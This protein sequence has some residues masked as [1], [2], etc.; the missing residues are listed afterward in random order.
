MA[1]VFRK[2]IVRHYG[3]DGKRCLTT[4]PGAARKV[5][6]SRKWYG[7]VGRQQVPLCSDKTRSQQMLN[8][9]LTDVAMRQHGLG[10]PYA[11]HRK[12]PL[13]NHLGEFRATLSAKGN[14]ARHV[15]LTV[16]NIQAVLDGTQ[17]IWL[18]DLDAGKASAWLGALRA[19]RQTVQLPAGQET[20]RLAEVADLLAVKS[21]SVTAAV[22]RQGLEATGAGPARR[23]PRA[24]VETLSDRAARGASPETVNHYVRSL[25]AFGRWL[26]RSKRCGSN[27]FDTL[28]LLTTSID[29]RRDRRELT[30]EELRQ[31]LRATR[32]SDRSFR[33]LTGPDRFMLYAIACGT[34]FRASA[35]ASLTPESFDLVGEMGTVTLAARHAKNRRTKVQPIQP[36]LAKL[37]RT[38]L[39]DRPAGQ[40]IWAGNWARD[41]C[42]A[43]MLRGDL[44]AAGIPYSVEGPDGPLYADFHALRH[45]Y[46]TLGGRA[47]I[48]LRTLQ[49]LAGHSTP[50]LTARYSH[51]RLH[52]LAGAIEK[53]PT[54]L[55]PAEERPAEDYGL[56]ATGTGGEDSGCTM[57]ARSACNQGHFLAS[58]G[59]DREV[60]VSDKKGR[61]RL[62]CQ[63]VAPPVISSRQAGEL[64]FEPRQA[65]PESAVL[66]LHHSPG[67]VRTSRLWV[68]CFHQT[69]RWPQ[70][71]YH[72][73]LPVA[74]ITSFFKILPRPIG[75]DKIDSYG[76]ESACPRPIELMRS[77]APFCQSSC[78]IKQDGKLCDTCYREVLLR[79]RAFLT[80]AA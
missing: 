6:R 80:T 16:A 26:A 33:G 3:P 71:N 23:Y 72:F 29:R 63:L 15:K 76:R 24:T 52:D 19:D 27:P 68:C 36:D 44:E 75:G 47:G 41:Y 39:A 11:E 34:G 37:L 40:P 53:L 57:V 14:C 70:K 64:G 59:I 62:I 46:L 25:R 48:D 77:C 18:A 17:A 1:E 43:E 58:V 21:A 22:R 35:L 54:F 50:V 55:P 66:P 73:A 4:T 67:V 5:E 30:A 20:F 7:T 65:D 28:D 49:E 78:S 56:A 32:A 69:G 2:Q 38:Y 51:R 10:D 9:L 45:T 61:N 79:Q 8:K 13:A 74:L 60:E 42:G 31:V 12:R